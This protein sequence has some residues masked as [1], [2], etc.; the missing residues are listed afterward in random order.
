MLIM[1][2][3]IKQGLEAVQKSAAKTIPQVWD[4]FILLIFDQI[5]YG[6]RGQMPPE[7]PQ[8]LPGGWTNQAQTCKVSS[9]Y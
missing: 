4:Q 1:I 9:I 8:L 3:T 6:G 5:W 7:L 2:I